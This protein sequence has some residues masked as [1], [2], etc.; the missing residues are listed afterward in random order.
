LGR[1]CATAC[2]SLVFHDRRSALGV[3]VEG[4]LGNGQG[5][6]AAMAS[7]D[8]WHIQ[9]KMNALAQNNPWRVGW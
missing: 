7:A 8:A 5:I 1:R 3:T 6:G 2:W 4:A 9:L